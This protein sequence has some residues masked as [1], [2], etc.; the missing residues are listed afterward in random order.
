MA[1]PTRRTLFKTV[2]PRAHTLMDKISHVAME[3]VND[4]T[5]QRETKTQR[6]RKTRLEREKGGVGENVA[7]AKRGGAQKR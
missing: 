7:S 6:L 2:A 5:K 4:E 1:D 3:I